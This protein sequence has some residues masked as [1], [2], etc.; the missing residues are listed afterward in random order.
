MT[1][2]HEK[3]TAMAEHIAALKNRLS[4]AKIEV[5]KVK[6]LIEEAQMAAQELTLKKE[7]KPV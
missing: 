7:E 5:L 2:K 1:C 3:I 6:L 4:F